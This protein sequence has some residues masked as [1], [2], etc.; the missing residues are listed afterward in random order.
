M[1]KDLLLLMQ[2][3]FISQAGNQ[4]FIISSLYWLLKESSPMLMSLFM[5]MATLPMV[6]FSPLGTRSKSLLRFSDSSSINSA[7]FNTVS[8]KSS[9]FSVTTL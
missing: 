5:I 3:Q 6:L 2:G 4:I 1:K 7:V 9:K 8:K